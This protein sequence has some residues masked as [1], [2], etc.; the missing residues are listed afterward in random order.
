MTWMVLQL[1]NAHISMSHSSNPL[2]GHLDGQHQPT[3][4]IPSTDGPTVVHLGLLTLMWGGVRQGGLSDPQGVLGWRRSKHG[5]SGSLWQCTGPPRT[6]KYPTRQPLILSFPIFL[7][8][9]PV[10]PEAPRPRPLSPWKLYCSDE[11]LPQPIF[12][13]LL[14]RYLYILRCLGFRALKKLFFFIKYLNQSR[15]S[16]LIETQ[17]CWLTFQSNLPTTRMLMQ[18]TKIAVWSLA[19]E[20][21]RLTFSALLAALVEQRVLPGWPQFPCSRRLL[22][23]SSITAPKF[24][25]C[26]WL[27]WNF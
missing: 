22:M 19:K 16:L 12:H 26:I 24:P 3:E 15:S 6:H 4:P 11:N 20:V 2:P 18:A 21:M 14:I 7:L 27:P 23:E 25:A 17:A 5:V 9:F 10:K 1:Q 13:C 8:E